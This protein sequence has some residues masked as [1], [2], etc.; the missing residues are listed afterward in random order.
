MMTHNSCSVFAQRRQRYT[1]VFHHEQQLRLVVAFHPAWFDAAARR[2]AELS[3]RA[4]HD[5]LA[6]PVEV[7]CRL[8]DA[9]QLH[10]HRSDEHCR[11][12]LCAGLW[13]GYLYSTIRY[14]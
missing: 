11:R 8:D 3:R 6:R 5:H 9:L 12:L 1:A 7:P 10:L 13:W 2:V 4:E 14:H